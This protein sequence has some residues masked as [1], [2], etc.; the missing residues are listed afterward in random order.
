MTDEN[1]DYPLT[2]E[3]ITAMKHSHHIHGATLPN[4]SPGHFL[5]WMMRISSTWMNRVVI[6]PR[7]CITTLN[8]DFWPP[9][10]LHLK[11]DAANMILSGPEPAC[12]GATVLIN[13]ERALTLY[14]TPASRTPSASP[15]LKPHLSV[16]WPHCGR[17]GKYS[18]SLGCTRPATRFCIRY[19]DPRLCQRCSPPR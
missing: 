11:A 2:R 17:R 9:Y 3:S 13:A 5:L 6:R 16:S 19:F 8:P 10:L 15:S 12:G 4:L 14:H 18:A 7:A 1:R